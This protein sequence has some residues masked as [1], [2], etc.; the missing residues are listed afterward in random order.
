MAAALDESGRHG[1]QHGKLV[2]DL[3]D[4]DLAVF[5]DEA[6]P[7]AAAIDHRA[8]APAEPAPSA[9]VE[10]VA[11]TKAMPSTE[12]VPTAKATAEAVSRSLGC[13]QAG[14]GES[15]GD[16][17]DTKHLEC[18]DPDPFPFD[19]VVSSASMHSSRRHAIRF[20]ENAIFF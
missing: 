19:E 4:D 11:T 15:E 14:P 10:A 12:A 3:L 18:H 9:V 2:A 13:S 8:H 6:L 16:R 20:M 1:H 7:V 5:I 17:C